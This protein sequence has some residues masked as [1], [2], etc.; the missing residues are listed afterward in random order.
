MDDY[1]LESFLKTSGGKGYHIVV[2]L[3]N[4]TTWKNARGIARNIAKIMEATWPDK[5][6]S[7]MKKRKRKGKI[8]I[9]WVRNI[10]G[11]TS[12]APYSI[13]LRGKATVSMPIKWSELDKVKPDEITMDKAIKRLNRVNPWKDFFK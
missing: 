8:F 9:D 11:T 13:R 7:N 5:Y 10:K 2:P 1:N 3:R 12:V 4:K 6:T